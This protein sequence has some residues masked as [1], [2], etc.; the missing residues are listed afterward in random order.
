[1]QAQVA[2]TRRVPAA[3]LPLL[4]VAIVLI[5]ASFAGGVAFE[6]GTADQAPAI[7]TVEP[8]APVVMPVT[9][10]HHPNEREIVATKS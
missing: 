5:V 4:L 8:G 3:W 1:M 10:V 9:A 6:H 2:P 7:T